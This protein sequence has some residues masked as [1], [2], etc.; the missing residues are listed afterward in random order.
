MIIPLEFYSHLRQQIRPSEIIRQKMPL[1]R[2]GSE[3][4]GLC[5]FHAEKTPS[6]TINDA[7]GFY[8]C[9]GCG[10]HGDVIKFVSEMSGLSYKE[11]SIKIANENG[12]AL[13]KMT[14]A[15]E[16]E[17][18]EVEKIYN[19]LELAS[20]YF[21]ANLSVNKEAEG[22]LAKRSITESSIK[23]F[24]LGYASPNRGDLIDFFEN[25]S[26]PLKDLL[27]SGLVGKK[28]DGRIY[29][30]FS[31]RIMFPIRNIYNKIVGFGGRVL[32]DALPKYIN[33]P[34]TVVFKKNDTMYGE[35]FAISASYKKNYSIIVEGY[36]DVIALN[37]VGVNE[38][39][40]SL[41]TAITEKHLQKLWRS[42][43]E[44]VICLDADEAGQRAGHRLID[45]ALPLL[46]ADKKLSFINLMGYKDP[47]ELI[48]KS[49]GVEFFEKLVEERV[50]LSKVIWKKEYQNNA[51]SSAES[52][53]KF[54]K[55]LDDYCIRIKD[56]TL[57]NSFR[58]YFKDQLW[59][60]SSY[61]KNN[62]PDF[63]KKANKTYL[64]K[65]KGKVYTE[66]EVIERALC[67]FVIKFPGVLRNPEIKEFMSGLTLSNEDLYEFKEWFIDL[68][69]EENDQK[70]D[71]SW[72]NGENKIAEHVKR[73]RF[74]ESFSLLSNPSEN[75]LDLAF[76][77]KNQA[78]HELIFNLLSKKLYLLSLK[79]EY[80]ELLSNPQENL[81]QKAKF[82]L[83]EIQETSKKVS[84]ISDF[85]IN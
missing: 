36:M 74:Y 12:I 71:E 33:S 60:E 26:I 30:I 31:N 5:P 14:L 23:K 37:Q 78:N 15:Q 67:G 17:Y 21:A 82:Y 6:F 66:M 50:D 38:V 11:A 62:H 73:T 51:L 68:L 57:A 65:D 58:R 8:H 10:A 13:P 61:K 42:S 25:K 41:G 16:K 19:I 77:S 72:V 18:E 44:I 47:D 2:K 85:F 4:L 81:Q 3:Y 29:E 76:I 83:K 28:E 43:D 53:A 40:A 55:T 69:T 84:E 63:F 52:R 24:G 54:E 34:E 20:T 35:N 22:Y 27:I 59:Q 48:N 32:G 49:K 80:A 46:T 1:S 9:F 70:T 75:F 39:V 79:Q 64:S 45:L 7:K 56:K